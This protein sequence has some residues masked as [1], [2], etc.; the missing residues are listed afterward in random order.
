MGL[1]SARS[2]VHGQVTRDEAMELARRFRE[3]GPND[4]N[5]PYKLNGLA[6]MLDS[7]EDY[8]ADILVVNGDLHVPGDLDLGTLGGYLLVDGDLTCGRLIGDY[9]DCSAFISGDLTAD[10]FYG[11]EHFFTIGGALHVTTILGD[12]KNGRPRMSTATEPADVISV[13]TTKVL[14][15]LDPELVKTYDDTNQDGQ[16]AVHIYSLEFGAIKRRVAQGLPLRTPS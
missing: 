8:A 15:H 13:R 11:E 12:P 9:N 5:G 4:P 10:L 1:E 3:G 14:E 2:F 16:L 7:I 6:Q